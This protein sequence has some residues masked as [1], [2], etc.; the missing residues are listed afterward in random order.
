MP[1][2]IPETAEPSQF[3]AAEKAQPAEQSGLRDFIEKLFNRDYPDK[4]AVESVADAVASG[5]IEHKDEVAGEALKAFRGQQTNEFERA[6]NKKLEE[7]NSP[8][9]IKID[10]SFAGIQDIG[11]LSVDLIEREW[12]GCG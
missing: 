5:K 8:Y 10:D 2:N 11:N 1:E 3:R 7:M 12:Q 4:K 9:K 6:V